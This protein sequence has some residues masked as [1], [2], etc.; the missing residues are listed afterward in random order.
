M[1]ASEVVAQ[2]QNELPKRT[3][4]FTD[5][6]SVTSLTRSGNTV[7]A[8][9]AVPH[10]LTTGTYV[11]VKGAKELNPITSLTFAD[12]IATAITQNDH[13]LTL[14]TE[15]MIRYGNLYDFNYADVEGANESEYNDRE[16]LSAVPN[17]KTF[18]YPVSGSP[19]TPATGS[20]A[21]RQEGGY[22]GRFEITVFDPT[23]FTYQIATTPISPAGGTILAEGGTR[24][25]SALDLGR[26][27]RS[28]TAQQTDE[29][30]L[31]V[32]ID[33]TLAVKDRQ[34][35]GDAV[36]EFSRQDEFRARLMENFRTFVFAPAVTAYGGRQFQDA[37]E[38]VRGFIYNSLLGRIF[39]TSLIENA[40]SKTAPTG[41]RFVA[42]G[43]DD[44]IYIHEFS[45][46]RVVDVTYPDTIGPEDNR[47]LRDVETETGY[48]FGTG[49]SKLES[50]I[51]L[52]E[53]P[54]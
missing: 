33:D 43:S 2:L 7:T 40:W 18:S 52:D 37:M 53:E 51:D 3:D 50:D 4:L 14:P 49:T 36:F 20:P 45:F 5:S 38:D 44:A 12:G 24:I 15:R 26:A 11:L 46:Q 54:L 17:R 28:Y 41:D 31:F 47:A 32:V 29:Y 6:V 8:V 34:I 39:S 48:D 23:T 21:L 42:E 19:S 1:R 10:N 22:N 16:I 35:L 27:L 9:T 30:W 25:S 13:D